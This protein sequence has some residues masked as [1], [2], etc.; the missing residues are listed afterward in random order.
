MIEILQYNYWEHF[1]AA[2]DVALILPPD[3]PKRQAIEKSMNQLL[4]EINTY[5]GVIPNKNGRVLPKKD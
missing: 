4:T 3:H 1:K 2:K 5:D